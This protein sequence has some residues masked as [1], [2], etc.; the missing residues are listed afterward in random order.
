MAKAFRRPDT[1]KGSTAA[2]SHVEGEELAGLFASYGQNF[3]P[4][5]DTSLLG[6]IAENYGG[7]LNRCLIEHVE[8][9]GAE[10]HAHEGF[11][12]YRKFASQVYQALD[13]PT[14][15][16]DSAGSRPDC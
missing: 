13:H 1:A 12:G 7:L 9:D 2:S 4:G 6:E 15:A 16:H 10:I 14:T 8:F 3:V 11:W 5:N